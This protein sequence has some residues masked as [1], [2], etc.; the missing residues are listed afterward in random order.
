MQ[1]TTTVATTGKKSVRDHGLAIPTVDEAATMFC[2]LSSSF[3]SSDAADGR[4]PESVNSTTTDETKQLL[5]GKRKAEDRSPVRRR[6]SC[7][8][9]GDSAVMT[10]EQADPSPR[11]RLRFRSDKSKWGCGLCNMKAAASRFNAER[12]IWYVI[13]IN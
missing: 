5:D 8:S 11:R 10:E 9:S 2:E 6:G 3:I 4:R 12:H 13:T 1:T 7:K